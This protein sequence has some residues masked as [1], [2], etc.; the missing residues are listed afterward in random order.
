MD[1]SDAYSDRP[2]P[3]ISREIDK[4]WDSVTRRDRA[5]KRI[6]KLRCF[7]RSKRALNK[8]ERLQELNDNDLQRSL[9]LIRYE[10]D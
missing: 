10:F 1:L 6:Q 8:I 9:C 2:N 7:K 4:L 5:I 3:K